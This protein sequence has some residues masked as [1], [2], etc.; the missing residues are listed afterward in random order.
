MQKH[1]TGRQFV[2]ILHDPQMRIE[3]R[4]ETASVDIFKSNTVWNLS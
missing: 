3:M 2:S 1:V 4:I